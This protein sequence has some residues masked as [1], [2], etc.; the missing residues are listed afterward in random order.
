MGNLRSQEPLKLPPPPPP[1]PSCPQTLSLFRLVHLPT[2]ASYFSN[3]AVWP[4]GLQTHGFLLPRLCQKSRKNN[5]HVHAFLIWVRGGYVSSTFLQFLYD[6]FKV[7]EQNP[8]LHV[9]KMCSKI[10]FRHSVIESKSSFW[11]LLY[12]TGKLRSRCCTSVTK[13]HTHI[14]L[15]WI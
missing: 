10:V 12:E 15:Q 3:P 6:C 14:L 5:E 4:Q 13:Q 11:I 8:L 7:G 9:H 1:M 2:L